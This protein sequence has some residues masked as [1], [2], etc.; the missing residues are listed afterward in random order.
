M[1][2]RYA[3]L[4]IFALMVQLLQSAYAAFEPRAIGARATAL[5]QAFAGG[6]NDPNLLYWNPSGLTT[7]NSRALHFSYQDIYSKGL[8]N[9]SNVTFAAPDIGPGAFGLSWTRLGVT[10]KA[11]FDYSENTYTV[12][13][14]YKWKRWISMGGNLS[15]YRLTSTVKGSGYGAGLSVQIRPAKSLALGV[16]YQ[17]AAGTTVRYDSGATDP[18]PENVRAGLALHLRESVKLY[19]DLD[20]AT[21]KSVL[22]SGVE[23]TLMEDAFDLRGGVSQRTDRGDS[24]VYAAGFGAKIRYVE[25]QYAFENHFDLGGSHVISLIWRFKQ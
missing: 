13:Y 2:P 18:L 19:A 12:G 9:L 24:L 1:K 6:E 5:G 16:S 8:V 11:P 3:A 15:F 22:H 23:I 14:G 20:S 4:I 25:L 7:M 17:N 21:R 10:N